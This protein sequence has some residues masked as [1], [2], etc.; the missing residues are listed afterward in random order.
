MDAASILLEHLYV[1]FQVHTQLI[2]FQ[3]FVILFGVGL[4]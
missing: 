1:K 2:L 4:V 3:V